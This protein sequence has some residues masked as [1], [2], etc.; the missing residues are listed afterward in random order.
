MTGTIEQII[1]YLFKQ[2]KSKQYEVKEHREKRSLNA[3]NYAWKL[4]TEIANVMRLSKEEVY[5]EMLKL[6]GQSEMVSV[7]A[8]I[9]VSK[10]FKYYSE[11]GES[12]LNGK[13]FKHYKVYMG[14]SEMDTKQMSILIDG[15]VQEAKQLDIEAMTPEQLSRL[16]EEWDNDS[17]KP[18]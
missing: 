10:Y 16:K 8:D 4:I 18:N 1:Q 5:I 14:S 9:D 7:L 6:Y 15:I 13:K 12:I 17:N 11:V 2:D 3:N